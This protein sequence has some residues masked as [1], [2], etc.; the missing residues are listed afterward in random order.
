MNE[1]EVDMNLSLQLRTEE[2]R[3]KTEINYY[4]HMLKE[5]DI[6]GK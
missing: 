5:R 2:K 3:K 4:V 6:C 1:S